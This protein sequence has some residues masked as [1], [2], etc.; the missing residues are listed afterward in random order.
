MDLHCGSLHDHC[1]WVWP[2]QIV[3]KLTLRGSI[4]KKYTFYLGAVVN[5]I[6]YRKIMFHNSWYYSPKPA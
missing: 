1:E 6:N 4:F 5:V 2:L 3:W